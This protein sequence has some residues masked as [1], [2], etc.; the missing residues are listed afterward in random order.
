MLAF[1]SYKHFPLYWISPPKRFQCP[2]FYDRKFEKPLRYVLWSSSI[3]PRRRSMPAWIKVWIQITLCEISMKRATT[4]WLD[5]SKSIP[6][7]KYT[8][9]PRSTFLV[10]ST[11]MG[12]YMPMLSKISIGINSWKAIYLTTMFDALH[13][14]TYEMLSDWRDMCFALDLPQTRYTFLHNRKLFSIT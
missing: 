10:Y 11:D 14:K 5:H 12:Q 2:P 13:R 9:S 1:S 3:I 8:A 6:S 4:N 7:S